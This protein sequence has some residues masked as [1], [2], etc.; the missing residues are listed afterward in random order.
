MTKNREDEIKQMIISQL[1]KLAPQLK[2]YRFF[3]CLAHEQ[4]VLQSRVLILMWV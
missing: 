4:T 3:F 1:H 2:G